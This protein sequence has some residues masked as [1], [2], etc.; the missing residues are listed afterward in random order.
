RASD[1][2]TAAA[3]ILSARS[4]R[5]A[6]EAAVDAGAAAHSG[7][8]ILHGA[9]RRLHHLGGRRRL[10]MMPPTA[11]KSNTRPVRIAARRT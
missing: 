6:G 11:A 7:S 5:S 10:V 1:R 2:V 8:I 4:C 3:A 9:A